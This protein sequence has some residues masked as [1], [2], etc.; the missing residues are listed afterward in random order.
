MNN[1]P[2]TLRRAT[3]TG[4]K[5]AVAAAIAAGALATPAMATA[6]PLSTHEGHEASAATTCTVE[7]ANLHWGVKSRFRA[8]ISGTIANG[9]W[10]VSDDMKYETPD[11]IWDKFVGAFPSDFADGLISF[12]GAV[13]FTGHEGALQFDLADPVIEFD[14]EDAAY[15]ALK[16]GAT[17]SGDASAVQATSVRVAKMDLTTSLSTEGTELKID[18]AVPR[19]T[20]EG[21]AAFNGE[22]GSYV[23]GEELDPIN[24]T[25]TISGCE[26]GSHVAE[27]APEEPTTTGDNAEVAEPAAAE[28]QIPWI[29]ITIGGIALV[30][31]GVTGGMLLG[32]RKKQAPEAPASSETPAE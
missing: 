29:P 16:I 17:D 31:I 18:G 8:Y 10:T 32:G 7:S 1:K 6:T 23:A 26:L 12:T 25:A 5:L 27:A 15:L 19:L 3:A 30:V 22:Y 11:F 9:E 28:Q 24:L 13:H 14:G 20:A 2:N 21:A 4:T